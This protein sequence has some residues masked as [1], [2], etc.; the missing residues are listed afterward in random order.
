MLLFTVGCI[1]GL[2]A[3]IKFTKAYYSLYLLH[4]NSNSTRANMFKELLINS[5]MEILLFVV[6]VVFVIVALVHKPE[7]SLVPY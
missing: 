7:V 3:I 1:L 6:I 5:A 2:L 4:K